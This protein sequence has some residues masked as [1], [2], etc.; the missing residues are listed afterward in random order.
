MNAVLLSHTYRLHMCKR[1]PFGNLEALHLV[2][3]TPQTV[4]WK[5]VIRRYLD[6]ITLFM[7]GYNLVCNYAFGTIQSFRYLSLKRALLVTRT[8]IFLG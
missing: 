6:C 8:T 2:M 4:V 3:W 1:R 7:F 5:L